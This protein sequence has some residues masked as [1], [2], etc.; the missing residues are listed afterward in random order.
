MDIDSVLLTIKSGLPFFFSHFLLT[1]AILL[2]GI[3]IYNFITPHDET[4]L[5]Q[6]GN[7]AAALS[8]LGAWIGIAM[9]LAFC[10]ATSL[11]FYD[12]LLWGSVAVIIQVTAFLILD[13]FLRNLSKRIEKGEVASGIFVFGVKISIAMIN[14]AAISG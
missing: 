8:S 9:P 6:K 5:I 11:G 10:M 13:K 7:V 3:L 1:V 4:K 12:I 14:S 2:I